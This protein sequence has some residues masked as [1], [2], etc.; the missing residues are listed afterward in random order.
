MLYT[1]AYDMG[2]N[3]G[4]SIESSSAP[5]ELNDETVETPLYK[6]FIEKN[7]R[8][9]FGEDNPTVPESNWI[10]G[11]EQTW[12]ESFKIYNKDPKYGSD[13]FTHSNKFYPQ[14]K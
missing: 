13:V 5:E 12:K 4:E 14:S 1:T 7:L 8:R 9:Q 10:K 2:Y 11:W 6:K 3:K